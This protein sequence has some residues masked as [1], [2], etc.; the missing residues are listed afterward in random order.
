MGVL[1]FQHVPFLCLP[2]AHVGDHL[3]KEAIAGV[4]RFHTRVLVTHQLHFLP[5]VDRV[6]V[7]DKGRIT[8]QGTYDQLCAEGVQFASL[9][10][11]TEP[12]GFG[13][14]NSGNL[15]GTPGPDNDYHMLP[16]MLQL[17]AHRFRGSDGTDISASLFTPIHSLAAT[18]LS[19]S[20]RN[21]P[22]ATVQSG[23]AVAGRTVVLE[24]GKAIESEERYTG[25]V[26]GAVY[27]QL[28]ACLG[29][30]KFVGAFLAV[31]LLREGCRT[32]SSL[33][34]AEWSDSPTS[35]T[36]RQLAVYVALG[37]AVA[38]AACVRNF[39][40]FH[41]CVTA[42]KKLHD[43]MLGAVLRAPMSW[44]NATP[45][46]RISSRFSGD[47]EVVDSVSAFRLR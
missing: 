40:W 5:H 43:R 29:G 44:F 30:W 28:I 23:G 39:A 21:L 19:A 8:H 3:F 4:L 32:A 27:K 26:G 12:E 45:L 42:S 22:V 14:R 47:L 9:V 46:G 34:I 7:M 17:F 33:W 16:S 31:A 13:A 24:A 18:F 2:D 11:P 20:T 25:V 15:N 35:K 37:L 10:A 36:S 6:I 38:L 41:A 1:F